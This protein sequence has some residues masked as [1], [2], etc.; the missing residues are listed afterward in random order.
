MHGNF[1]FLE[2]ETL[3]KCNYNYCL[4]LVN[5]TSQAFLYGS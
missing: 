2:G 3:K 5:I 4:Y 1:E